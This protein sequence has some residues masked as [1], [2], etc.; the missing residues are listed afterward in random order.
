[1]KLENPSNRNKRILMGVG[2]FLLLLAA[3]PSALGLIRQGYAGSG[4]MVGMFGVGGLVLLMIYLG[5]LLLYQAFKA[6]PKSAGDE[7]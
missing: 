6:S 4:D 7:S 5:V 1:M 3:A 2:G